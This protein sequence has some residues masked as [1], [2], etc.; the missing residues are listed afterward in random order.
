MKY[1]YQLRE[2]EVEVYISDD[3]YDEEV[4]IRTGGTSYDDILQQDQDGRFF[5][6]N[7]DKIYE[8]DLVLFQY[9][10]LRFKIEN[11]IRITPFELVQGM[12]DVSLIRIIYNEESKSCFLRK[13]VPNIWC[14]E[15]EIIK[16]KDKDIKKRY[17]NSYNLA[18]L[19]NNK[20]LKL[21][22]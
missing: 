9:P 18:F 2:N 17:I 19:I 3:L 21:L 12:K 11:G 14:N 1:T 13:C 15:F 6:F 22:D 7:K 16:G 4:T 20:R 8:K 10:E 5:V